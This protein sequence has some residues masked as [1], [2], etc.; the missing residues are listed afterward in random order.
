MELWHD[1]VF[2]WNHQKAEMAT[3][4][5]AMYFEASTFMLLYWA[6]C[7]LDPELNWLD[8]EFDELRDKQE[9]I[10][11]YLN[12]LTSFEKTSEALVRAFGVNGKQMLEHVLGDDAGPFWANY[13]LCRRWRNQIAH[14]GK[15]MYYET[16][17][18]DMRRRHQPTRDRSLRASLQFVPQCWVAFSKLWNEYIYRPMWAKSQAGND[19]S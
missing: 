19:A 7:W 16:L 12:S 15:R 5:A 17:P 11:A 18:E 10:Q 1:E 13:M 8:A 9:R 2:C 3:V 14:R 4:V 6:T